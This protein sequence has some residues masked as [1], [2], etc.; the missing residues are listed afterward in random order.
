M[1]HRT[2]GPTKIDHVSLVMVNSTRIMEVE[3]WQ[4]SSFSW[5]ITSVVDETEEWLNGNFLILLRQIR[6]HRSNCLLSS[7]LIKA[8]FLV[9]FLM[10]Y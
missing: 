1:L 2:L 4:V 8:G 9:R 5:A 7:D 3:I 10:S 6:K